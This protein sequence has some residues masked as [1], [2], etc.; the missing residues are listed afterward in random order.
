VIT[1]SEWE[2]K[3][4]LGAALPRPEEIR[5]R[6]RAEAEAF[7][8]AAGGRFV[9]KA[10][11]IAHKT[12]GG[13]VRSGL[14]PADV[15]AVWQALAD[16]GDGTVIVA[17]QLE[18]ELELIVGGYRDPAFGP[19]VTVGIGGIA[20]EI[21]RDVA[22][23]LAPPDPGEVA[24]AVN[25]LAG[26]RLFAGVRGRPPVDLAALEDIVLLVAG[27]FAADPDIAEI[28]CNPVMVCDGRPLVADALVVLT[29]REND[30]DQ[31][32]GVGA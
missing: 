8:A 16:A 2:S 17:R 31:N 29:G 19:V 26:R 30:L 5:S 4:R 18:A 11:G 27:A 3:R 1:L 22:A 14:A 10:S 12:E 24:A 23:I 32:S 28:D 7:A 20:A 21:F 13:L 6:T 15:G 9:A 25:E